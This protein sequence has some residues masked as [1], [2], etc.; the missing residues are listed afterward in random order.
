MHG[1]S[2][3]NLKTISTTRGAEKVLRILPKLVGSP[4]SAEPCCSAK[5]G[6]LRT[7][8]ASTRNVKKRVGGFR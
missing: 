4:M 2:N 7:L 5:F 3:V 1:N 6:W 8:N